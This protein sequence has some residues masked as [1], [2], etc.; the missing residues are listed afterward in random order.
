MTAALLSGLLAARLHGHLLFHTLVELFTIVVE[1]SLFFLAWHSRRFL[2]QQYLLL[3]GIAS[4]F[5]G[6]IDVFHTL[7]YKG[8]GVLPGGGA[9]QA[10][11]F[12]IAGRWVQAISFLVAPVFFRRRLNPH[13]TLAIYAAVT[14]ALMA[15][16]LHQPSYFPDCFVP[17]AG[18]TPFKIGSEYAVVVLLTVSAVLLVREQ[19]ELDSTVLRQILAAIFLTISAG[20]AFTLYM[21]VYGVTNVAGHLLRFL[22]FSLIYRAFIVTGLERPCDLLF[23]DLA[24]SEE[25]L[26]GVNAR[27]Q[28]AVAQLRQSDERYRAFVAS[29]SQGICRVE[30][31][32]PV[33][34]ELPEEEFVRL[35][36]ERAYVAE[37]NDVFASMDGTQPLGDGELLRAFHRSGCQRAESEIC[38]QDGNGAPR[39][40]DESLTG[41]VEDGR[42]LRIWRVR[43]DVTAHKRAA[44]ERE[45]L[46]AD[47][48]KALA[49]VKTLS[50]LLPI[51]ANCK[52]I[53]DDG[54]YWTQVESYLLQ[55]ADVSFT[56]GI[57]PDCMRQLYPDF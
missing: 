3:I 1:C 28:Q 4:L 33:P 39:W 56:H 7:A 45:R 5:V 52:K 19:R 31:Q 6:L 37:S 44:A 9:N 54:G 57:C 43:R 41:V 22:A 55:K 18:L 15:A 53:R 25:A 35:L 24:Q 42:L 34:L 40:V 16:I 13:L 21:D 32:T 14:A 2:K 27:L 49:E 50:G 48:R 8:M 38:E 10:T 17:G 51:C 20:L 36:L 26:R 11:Q 12:W 46:I 29:S 47:L 23:R 30:T